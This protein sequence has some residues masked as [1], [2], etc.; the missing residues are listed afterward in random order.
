[1]GKALFFDIDGTLV[2][3]QGRMP[4]SAKDALRRAQKNGHKIVLCSGRSICQIYPWLLD[5]GF[6]GAVCGTGAYVE[7]DGRII[8]EHHMDEA[9][10]KAAKI[11][12]EQ[13]GACFCAQTKNG[14]VADAEGKRRAV[15]RFYSMGLGEDMINQV[16]KAALV[17]EHLERRTDI[18]K[19]LFYESRVPVAVIRE[20]LCEYSDVTESSFEQPMDDSGEV[21]HKGIN[22]ALGMRKY[23]EHAKIAREDTIAF[24]DGPNDFDMLEYAG[25]GAAMGNGIPALKERADYVAPGMEEDGIA[26]AL[27]ELGII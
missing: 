25:L 21:T 13:A 19:L 17:D 10:L 4:D 2:D 5:M 11:V 20:Q 6:D 3:F 23:I 9:A 14:V 7:C 24:G 27:R 12:L 16:W 1:M 22:K 18:E 26:H 8:Y 15:N